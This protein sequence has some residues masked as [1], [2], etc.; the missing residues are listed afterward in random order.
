MKKQFVFIIAIF[1]TTFLACQQNSSSSSLSSNSTKNSIALRTD[2]DHFIPIDSANKMLNSFL[3]STNAPND[4]SIRSYILDADQLREYLNDTSNGKI[5]SIKIMMAHNL[6]YINCGNIGVNCGYNP[7]GL[8]LII[9]GVNE[10]GNYVYKSNQ[11]MDNMTV[12]PTYCYSTG[13]AS[14][15]TLSR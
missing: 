3:R 13:T 1:A 7:S 6:S 12:C 11:V 2:R 5:T 9:A 14:F 4:S 10:S 15:D 8:T